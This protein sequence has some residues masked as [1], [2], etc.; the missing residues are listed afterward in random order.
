M[1]ASFSVLALWICDPLRYREDRGNVNLIFPFVLRHR[2]RGT[3]PY[4]QSE[5][6][7]WGPFRESDAKVTDVWPAYDMSW[8]FLS[9]LACLNVMS[10]QNLGTLVRSNPDYIPRRAEKGVEGKKKLVSNETMLSQ[11]ANM[12]RI[13]AP[14]L[15]N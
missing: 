14:V 15:A 13:L 8:Y 5:A 12:T 6:Q 11:S 4:C 10:S 2:K 9:T 7:K 3:Y 1:G